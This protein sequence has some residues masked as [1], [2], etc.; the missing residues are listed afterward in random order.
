MIYSTNDIADARG[1]KP[2]A[3]RMTRIYN[4]PAS[5]RLNAMETPESSAAADEGRMLHRVMELS[6]KDANDAER[7]ELDAL[8]KSLNDE[9]MA[10]YQ[11]TVK[12]V[13]KSVLREHN[14]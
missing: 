3:S 10:A 5:L 4:C 14:A 6:I 11:T 12:L 13:S 9:Q 7:A 1:G 2:S 8:L